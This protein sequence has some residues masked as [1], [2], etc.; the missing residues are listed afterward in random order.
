MRLVIRRGL[1]LI[2]VLIAIILF[3]VGA[4]GLAATSGSIARQLVSSDQRSRAA[5]RARSRDESAHATACTSSS[6]S[7]RSLGIDATWTIQKAGS[8]ALIDQRLERR[9]SKGLHIEAFRSG[10]PCD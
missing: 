8:R 6:G 4:L 5:A 7:E 1:S 10:A 9:D 3:A 2:E